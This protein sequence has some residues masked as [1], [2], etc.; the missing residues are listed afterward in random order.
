M[1]TFF[2]SLSTLTEF[3]LITQ[4]RVVQYKTSLVSSTSCLAHDICI[5]TRSLIPP[6]LISENLPQ[7]Y[8]KPTEHHKASSAF[9]VARKGRKRCLTPCLGLQV[10]HLQFSSAQQV[11]NTLP[12][13]TENSPKHS[14]LGRL[15]SAPKQTAS[16]CPLQ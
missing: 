14:C 13:M 9:P 2:Y 5:T 15:G 16:Q 4:S 11:S 12:V 3:P 10:H 1:S 7:K 6:I 8:T